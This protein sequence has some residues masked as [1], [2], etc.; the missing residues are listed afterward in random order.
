ML[1]L[2]YTLP[3]AK[4]TSGRTSQGTP[5]PYTSTETAV[6]TPMTPQASFP[7]RNSHK[8][9]NSVILH[10]NSLESNGTTDS[11]FSLSRKG[12][13][14]TPPESPMSPKKAGYNPQQQMASPIDLDRVTEA[15]DEFQ[16]R[17]SESAPLVPTT[18]SSSSSSN[19]LVNGYGS[20]YST[21]ATLT[22]EPPVAPATCPNSK[23]FMESEASRRRGCCWK[24]A[25]SGGNSGTVG[26]NCSTAI[27][28]SYTEGWDIIPSSTEKSTNSSGNF[29]RVS[30]LSHSSSYLERIRRSD[31]IR[32][33]K[34]I[35]VR[36][37]LGDTPDQSED[38]LASD[39]EKNDVA[40]S[41]QSSIFADPDLL[42]ESS[43]SLLAK[44]C[45]QGEFLEESQRCKPAAMRSCSDSQVERSKS[46]RLGRTLSKLKGKAVFSHS[47][48]NGGQG[49][50][51]SSPSSPRAVA[52]QKG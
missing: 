25:A 4:S 6:S 16:R 42:P 48:S 21:G 17:L 19:G 31:S 38:E 44:F 40:A 9:S 36:D 47:N 1:N 14:P 50:V 26:G 37:F 12:S 24:K 30:T 2:N 3:G 35:D 34:T 20:Y 15:S 46:K 49:S 51:P 7:R 22:K 33:K 43:K 5:K 8:R 23:Y 52:S 13:F 29:S 45:P 32:R 27:A 39:N 11:Y 18:S 10:G 28:P 41:V